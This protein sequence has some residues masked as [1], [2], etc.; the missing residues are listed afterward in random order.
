MAKD[1]AIVRG[2]ARDEKDENRLLAAGVKTIYRGDKGEILGKF[3]MRDKEL[4][5]VV[6]GLRAFGTT[7]SEMISAVKLMKSWGAAIIDAETKLRSDAD[8]AE[9]LDDGLTKFHG[10]AKMPGGS[11]QAR[12]M[13]TKSVEIRTKG[14]MPRHEAEIIWKDTGA[15]TLPQAL[16]LMNGWSQSSAYRVLGD[17]GAKPGRRERALSPLN[18][19]RGHI[20]FI[21]ANGKGPVKIGFAGSLKLRLSGL[22]TSHHQKLRLVAAIEGTPAHEKLLHRK[23]MDYRMKGEWFK[24]EGELLKYL[25][26][27]PAPETK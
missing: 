19:K 15:F 12:L 21:R 24:V 8:G 16:A 2:F 22:Q 26:T 1:I 9:M 23:F 18:S 4:L 5:G 27:L 20:Y 6:D 25:D 17:R 3:K 7:R 14:R 10:E 13:Q 11:R